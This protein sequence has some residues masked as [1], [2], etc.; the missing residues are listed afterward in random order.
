MAAT[1]A[2]VPAGLLNAGCLDVIVAVLAGRCEN[3]NS[4]GTVKGFVER[5]GMKLV[6]AAAETVG[7]LVAATGL[8]T[9]V[10]DFTDSLG[11]ASAAT[12]AG[13]C[14]SSSKVTSCDS[15]LD[16]MGVNAV[17]L[18]M[19]VRRAINGVLPPVRPTA[20]CRSASGRLP[21]AV[22]TLAPLAWLGFGP[23]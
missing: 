11:G 16:F 23:W 19:M 22:S 13:T 9:A 1:V 20:S 2:K 7:A 15:L 4:T 21:L 12:A 6:C 5:A 17:T 8:V 14:A 18:L 10:A 3:L